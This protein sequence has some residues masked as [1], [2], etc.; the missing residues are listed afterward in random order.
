MALKNGVCRIA[1]LLTLLCPVTSWAVMILTVTSNGEGMFYLRGSHVSGVESVD[2]MVDYDTTFLAAPEVGLAGGTFT[3]LSS[4]D[5]GRIYAKI[6]R[7][8]PDAEFDLDVRFER[9][10]ESP[11]I[12]N[13]VTATMRDTAGRVFPVPVSII[14]P[15]PPPMVPPADANGKSDKAQGASD[16]GRTR[17][18]GEVGQGPTDGAPGAGDQPA[19]VPSP[20]DTGGT[21]E[22]SSDTE[23]TPPSDAAGRGATTEGS[24]YPGEETATAANRWK[25]VL[26]QF[27][28]FRG[29]KGARELAALFQ[30]SAGGK[31]VQDPAIAISDGKTP[32]K[33]RLELEQVGDSAPNFGLSDA[34]FV[35]LRR[36]GERSWD[37]VVVP[38]AGTWQAR[39]IIKSG[40]ELAEFPLVV[41]PRIEL[42]G[43]VNERNF[44]AELDRYLS[45]QP[46]GNQ[47]EGGPDRRFLLEYI[48]TA[49]FLA[50]QAAQLAK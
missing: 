38:N 15:P 26:Q 5:P 21:A 16:A 9:R 37:L 1:T 28:D 40:G 31:I 2:I 3:S 32:V 45:G 14:A 36:S 48:F 4:D 7:E 13:F 6:V 22:G 23:R 11:G 46:A 30:Q 12:I 49:N 43:V 44:R 18:E 10:G 8:Y 50:K 24:S 27:H 17:K 25:G 33:I 29:S 34:R 35:S 41:V 39:L 42:A 20:K 47:E 19:R